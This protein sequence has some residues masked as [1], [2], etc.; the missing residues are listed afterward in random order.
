MV[1]HFSS[2]T[3]YLNQKLVVEGIGTFI[4]VLIIG[5]SSL[6]SQ[7]Q[8]GPCIASGCALMVLVYAGGHISGAHYNPA[9]TFA[10]LVRGQAKLLDTVLPYWLVQ[11][12]GAVVG[13]YTARGITGKIGNALPY[14]SSQMGQVFLSESIFTFTLVY[15][16]L[17]VAA[18][19]STK[20]NSYYGF[21]I[22]FTV[23][24][25]SFAVGSISGGAFNPAV[26]LGCGIL[27]LIDISEIWLHII[28]DFLGA[29]VAARVHQFVD[30]PP[31]SE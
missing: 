3:T 24:G 19:R 29:T 1:Y 25:G 26:A 2:S 27:N 23:T 10:L 7:T 14:S 28:A 4:F 11:I 30:P 31:D 22:G 5:C 8:E 18:S 16:V 13:A 15:V 12:T 6:L 20:G 21:A 17:N 9:V